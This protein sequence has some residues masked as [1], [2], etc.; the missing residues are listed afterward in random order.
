VRYL[1]I[2]VDDALDIAEKIEVKPLGRSNIKRQTR[3]W[4]EGGRVRHRLITDLSLL[5]QRLTSAKSDPSL[6]RCIT[7]VPITKSRVG[8]MSGG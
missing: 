5:N 6:E 7:I 8:K 3:A 4:E 1:G 2:E